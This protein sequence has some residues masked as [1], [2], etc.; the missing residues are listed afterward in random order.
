MLLGGAAHLHTRT[1]QI[2]VD[3]QRHHT[4]D[5][6]T[7]QRR[8]TH[9]G[10]NDRSKR[11]TSRRRYFLWRRHRL[12]IRIRIPN[13]DIRYIRRLQ[14]R[15]AT[16]ENTQALLQ[17]RAGFLKRTVIFDGTQVV[18][19]RPCRSARF[20]RV[21]VGDVHIIEERRPTGRIVCPLELPRRFEKLAARIV[22]GTDFKVEPTV[23][24]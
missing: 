17:H 8:A 6:A 16:F 1:L 23:F 12:G 5:H 2:T 21:A 19:E 7:D 9:A 18:T 14:G 20:V 15:H 24:V 13:F 4:G 22:A 3:P 10:Q 11:H